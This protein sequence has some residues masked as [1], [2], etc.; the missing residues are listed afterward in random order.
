[1]AWVA[2][3]LAGL[4]EMLGVN[5]I[6]GY[7]KDKLKKNIIKLILLFLVSF[8]LLSF[9]MEILPMSTAY[10]VW[11]GIGAVGGAILGII[12]YGESKNWKRLLCIGIVIVA[13]IGLKVVS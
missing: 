8:I 4:F 9:A 6:N 5:S 1:M 7:L 13:T 10:A 3:V 2:L 11:T 12:F